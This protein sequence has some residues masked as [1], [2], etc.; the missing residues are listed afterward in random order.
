MITDLPGEV[1]KA[2]EDAS[3]F[4]EWSVIGVMSCGGRKCDRQVTTTIDLQLGPLL[5]GAIITEKVFSSG[6]V[7]A[8]C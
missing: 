7:S 5:T 4:E 2:Q 8:V 1:K 3:I 6:Q